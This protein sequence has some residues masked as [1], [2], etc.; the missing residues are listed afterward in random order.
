MKLFKYESYQVTIEPEALTLKPFKVIWDRDKSKHKA[1]EKAIPVKVKK[2]TGSTSI[3]KRT[4][5]I[6]ETTK[7]HF[8]SVYL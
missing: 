7:K 3:L 6:R 8:V 4:K 2:M 1:T 5:N